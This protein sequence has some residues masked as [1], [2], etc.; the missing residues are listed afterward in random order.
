MDTDSSFPKTFFKATLIEKP[1]SAA[2]LNLRQLTK[3]A[4]TRRVSIAS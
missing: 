2:H 1:K 3:K 4:V